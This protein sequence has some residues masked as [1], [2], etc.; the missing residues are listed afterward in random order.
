MSVSYTDTHDGL[1]SSEGMSLKSRALQPHLDPSFIPP[2][3]VLV[4]HETL[5]GGGD[6]PRSTSRRGIWQSRNAVVAVK[7][8]PSQASRAAIMDLVRQFQALEHNNVQ[9]VLGALSSI[10]GS[11]SLIT[12]FYDNGNV[13]QYLGNHRDAVRLKL[14]H[15]TAIGMAYLHSQDMIHGRLK[16]SNIL[17]NN[18]NQACVADC[19]LYLFTSMPAPASYLSP[20][21]WKGKISKQSDMYAF[22]MV[23]YA[24]YTML[25]PWGFLP[26]TQ[27][28][29]LVTRENERP[30]RPLHG[31]S[32]FPMTDFEWETVEAGW[33][34][35]ASARPTF[36]EIVARISEHGQSDLTSLPHW[37]SQPTQSGSR[38]SSRVSRPL[39]APQADITRTDTMLTAPPAYSLGSREP[40][41]I[42][43]SHLSFSPPAVATV[44]TANLG[45]TPVTFNHTTPA[46]SRPLPS[47]PPSASATSPS[48]QTA[49]LPS[50]D[51]VMSDATAS[52][53]HLRESRPSISPSSLPLSLGLTHQ[54]VSSTIGPLRRVSPRAILPV[55]ETSPG[56]PTRKPGFWGRSS[57]ITVDA[58]KAIAR[59]PHVSS[60]GGLLTG[61][62]RGVGSD[63]Q[64]ISPLPTLSSAS[65]SAV[66]IA[67]A[68]HAEVEEGRSIEAIDHYLVMVRELISQSEKEVPKFITA[69]VVPTLIT[70][71]KSRASHRI[72]IEIVLKT[73]GMLANDPLSSNT[74]S[75]TNTVDVLLEILKT[76]TNS[77]AVDLSIWCLSR[78]SRSADAAMGLV[79][80][81]L[82]PLLIQ[83]GLGGSAATAQLT[84]WCLGNLVYNQPL[85]D[86]LVSHGAVPAIVDQLRKTLNAGSAAQPDDFCAVLYVIARISR[87]IKI[88][89]L[90]HESGAIEP[91]TSCFLSSE[92]PDVL[93]WCARAVGCLMR[94]NSADMAKILLEGGAAR[95]LARLP[96]VIPSEAISPLEAFAFAIQ[97]FSCAE[98]GSSTRM[99]LVEAGVV[100]S[101]LAAVRTAADV[102]FPQV[103]IELACAVSLLGDVGGGSIRKEIVR[104][105]G[106]DILKHVGENGSPKVSK[107]C[108]MAVRSITGNLLTR[109]A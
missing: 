38:E 103:H 56:T 74:I 5:L 60:L 63:D 9:K 3:Q 109:N 26:D 30:D 66:N 65:P 2:G 27:I 67:L 1:T 54:S 13:L 21:A 71:V 80:K 99:A 95:G 11:T 33:N 18:Q 43:G 77:D 10:S 55:M 8:L 35:I 34:A 7:H 76:S 92:D 28:Y 32:P 31:D 52:T 96:Q 39:L 78:L 84:S 59:M 105:G 72:G 89:K 45:I 58:A 93:M 102:P 17:V 73:L 106:I 14:I 29:Q 25:E 42:R 44:S 23:I 20:E 48:F 53:P 79:K 94:P 108:N 64:L 22:A 19:G 6:L 4:D 62:E 104:A 107:A 75:R 98:W 47:P 69:G 86:L 37:P 91:L 100:D 57:T 97:R 90:L 16:P 46:A 15:E 41:M 36:S 82:L 51:Q 24:M 88:A 61:G 81:D 40:S 85:A 68:L 101:L 87:S 70:L 83:K 12:P 49:T 50:V